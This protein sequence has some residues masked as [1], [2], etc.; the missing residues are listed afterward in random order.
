MGEYRRCCH[1]C[2]LGV[3]LVIDNLVYVPSDASPLHQILK[4]SDS[5]LWIYCISKICGIQSVVW[6]RTQLSLCSESVTFQ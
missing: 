6:L 4:Q 1:K 5:W 3:Y 2:S